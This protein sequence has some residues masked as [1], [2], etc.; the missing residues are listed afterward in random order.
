MKRNRALP[1]IKDRKEAE[2][3]FQEWFREH[4][5]AGRALRQ[6]Q[7]RKK[8]LVGVKIQSAIDRELDTQGPMIV[9]PAA[10]QARGMTI[11]PENPE[12]SPVFRRLVFLKFGITFR[13]LIRQIDIEKNNAAHRKLMGVHRDYWRLLSG[14]AFTNFKLKFNWDHFD[15]ITQGLDFGINTLTAD[16]L[17]ECFDEICPCGRE[18]SPEYLKKL[19][20][21]IMKA[22]DG[23][24]ESS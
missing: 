20:A 5:V 19:R 9:P 23:L 24:I 2:L 22:C 15:I 17:S 16:E 14:V 18:H 4:V 8:I 12:S 6:A 3:Y 7:D 10:S 11:Y 13:E 1:K 21:R